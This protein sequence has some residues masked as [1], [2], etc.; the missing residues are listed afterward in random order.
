MKTRRS[1]V[2]GAF[3]FY[4]LISIA[5]ISSLPDE[6]SLISADAGPLWTFWTE[7]WFA[8]FLA[9]VLAVTLFFSVH[10]WRR[11]TVLGWRR[12]LWL[13]GFWLLGPVMLPAYWWADTHAT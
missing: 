1:P 13:A 10:A 12:V 2:L 11:R 5:V 3:A 4:P 8:L 7:W 6:P 9:T